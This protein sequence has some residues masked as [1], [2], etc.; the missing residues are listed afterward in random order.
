MDDEVNG[1]AVK[2]R[3]NNE[4]CQKSKTKI[5]HRKII[6]IGKIQKVRKFG[7]FEPLSES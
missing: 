4:T 5:W 2:V 6:T 3:I 1:C 7:V